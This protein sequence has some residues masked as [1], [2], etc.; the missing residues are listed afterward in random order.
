MPIRIKKRAARERFTRCEVWMS[1]SQLPVWVQYAQALG[2]A[3]ACRTPTASPQSSPG[4]RLRSGSRRIVAAGVLVAAVGSPLLLA[5]QATAPSPTPSMG[6]PASPHPAS[7]PIASP[8]QSQ[9][10]LD[11]LNAETQKLREE[12]HA[13]RVTNEAIDPISKWAFGLLSAAGGLVGAC[14]AAFLVFVADRRLKTSQQARLEQERDLE[15]E[16]QSLALY[17]GLGD[18]SFRTRI[19]SASVLLQRLSAYRDRPRSAEDSPSTKDREV[20]TIINVLVSLLKE[21]PAE[22]AL[23][24]VAADTARGLEP[25]SMGPLASSASTSPT[26]S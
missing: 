19:A 9:L 7:T 2:T 25:L 22:V 1:Q 4:M 14:F 18:G 17:N 26:T 23:E 13:L 10:E 8:Q 5:A 24:E 21:A 6:S 15:R 20:P 3:D 16:K 12:I 11:K